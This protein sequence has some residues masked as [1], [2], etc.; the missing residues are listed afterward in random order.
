MDRHISKNFMEDPGTTT[1]SR[2]QA[3]AEKKR[4]G[5]EATE[6]GETVKVFRLGAVT[7]TPT[8]A[9]KHLH[10]YMSSGQSGKKKGRTK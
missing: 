9:R 8:T 2:K 6:G 3:G 1:R 5:D 7:T 4:K 10:K